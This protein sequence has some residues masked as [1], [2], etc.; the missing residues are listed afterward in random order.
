MTLMPTKRRAHAARYTRAS[1]TMKAPGKLNLHLRIT[2]KRPDGYHEIESLFVPV[3]LWDTLNVSKAK[4]G[5]KVFCTGRELPEGPEN[6]VYRA[7]LSFFGETGIGDGARIT[8]VKKIPI[9][10]GLGGGS[11]DAAATLKGLNTLWDE[12]LVEKDLERLALSLGADVPF[13]LLQRPAIARGIGELL[14]P[15]RVF[16]VFWYVIVSPDFTVS[17]AWAYGE[18]RLK[19]TLEGNRNILNIF[20]ATALKIPDLLLN[21]LESVTLSKYPF[22]CSIKESLLALGALGALMTGSGPSIFGVFESEHKANEAGETLRS[23]WPNYEVFIAK[24][25]E[26]GC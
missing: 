11:S 20:N 21:D 6:L 15:L 26:Q 18:V 5:L 14:E 19:L 10:S 3:A 4:K 2:G 22:L 25:L 16:P 13:F 7:A 8:L 1:I 12:P 23:T 17:T 9:S 24:G